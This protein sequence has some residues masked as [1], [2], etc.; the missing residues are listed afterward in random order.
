VVSA[1]QMLAWVDGREQSSFTGMSMGGGRLSFTINPGGGA[2]GLQAMVP[3]NGPTGTLLALARNGQAVGYGVQNIKGID[4]AMFDAAAGAYV[5]TYPAP[6][7]TPG[8]TPP[9]ARASKSTRV[10]DVQVLPRATL[11]PTFPRLKLST[12]TLRPGGGRSL[13]I[14]FRLRHTSR[15][16]LTFRTTKGKIVRRIRTPRRY[17]AGT[18]LR[19]RWDGR[20]SKGRYVK[21]ARYRFTLTATGSHYQKTARGSVR[22]LAATA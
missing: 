16:V 12:H 8:A 3:I 9:I 22:V 20:D 7:A 5:A 10:K 13:A 15:V 11:A 4:Y 14:T 2:R 1:R 19:L 6:A 21:P 17:K 18:V